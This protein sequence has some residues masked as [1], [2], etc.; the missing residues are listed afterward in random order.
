VIDDL[1]WSA[2]YDDSVDDLRA[3][4]RCLL[5]SQ[6]RAAAVPR[7]ANAAGKDADRESIAC[8]RGSG[9]PRSSPRM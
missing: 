5:G 1:T 9:W 4:P 8:T 7:G 3:L 6:R 2:L